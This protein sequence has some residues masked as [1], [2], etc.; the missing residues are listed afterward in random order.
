MQFFRT[1]NDNNRSDSSAAIA[2]ERLQIIVAHERVNR[3]GHSFLPAMQEDIL[4]V[5]RQYI[6]VDQENINIRLDCEGDCSVLE[7]NVQLPENE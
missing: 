5:I 7:V 1:P 4:N 6:T 2:K 3:K